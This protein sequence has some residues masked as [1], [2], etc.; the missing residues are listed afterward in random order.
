MVEPAGRA[1]APLE[2]LARA[3]AAA[4]GSLEVPVLRATTVLSK[5][6]AVAVAVAL[7]AAV[8]VTLWRCE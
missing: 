4:R 1:A 2:R 3:E 7:L 6:V 5:L 8:P